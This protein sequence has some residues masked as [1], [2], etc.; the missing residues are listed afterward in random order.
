MKV[1]SSRVWEY[2][3]PLV[4]LDAA[5]G[6]A[7]V[8]HR[9]DKL[10][11]TLGGI[12]AS[13]GSGGEWSGASVLASARQDDVFAPGLAVGARG[14]SVA[15]WQDL[16]SIRVAG[17]SAG[18]RF[19]RARTLPGRVEGRANPQVAVGGDGTAAVVYPR[20]EGGLW[21]LTRRAG[22]PW[23]RASS[24][25]AISHSSVREVRVARDSRRETILAWL[26][27]SG[28]NRWVQVVVL[29]PGNRPERAPQTLLSAKHGQI[30]DLCLAANDRGNAVVAWREKRNGG[31][32][33][34]SSTRRGARFVG[35]VTVSRERD[36]GELSAAIDGSGRA[37]VAYTRVL[38]TQPGMAEGPGN[39]YPAYTQTAAV[40]IA[41]KVSGEGWT[42]P[43]EIAPQQKDST[44]EPQLAGAA[45]GTGLVAIWTHARFRSSETAT[46]TG[47]IE[48]SSAAPTGGIWQAPAVVSATG[49][50]AP[51]LA[52]G[53]HGAIAAWVSEASGTQAIETSASQP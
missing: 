10:N 5:G 40:E 33:I 36:T 4:A 23:R 14:Q 46:Y 9:E 3:R 26:S 21:V 16:K 17:G 43:S 7:L 27:G 8:W 15:V 25:A 49:S 20:L 24:A 29:G 1:A 35:P 38:R 53:G 32:A 42:K 19:A 51:T 13:T 2:G 6:G 45:T 12:E 34:E 31:S 28:G 41:T 48:A 11:E 50:F 18:G 22:G 37:A 52:V 44:F 30:G 47:E 39:S